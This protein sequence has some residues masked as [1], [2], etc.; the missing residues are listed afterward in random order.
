MARRPTADHADGL[1]LIHTLSDGKQ[2]RHGPKRL[3]TK[4]HIQPSGNHTLPKVSQLIAERNH[5]VVKKLHLIN[6]DKISCKVQAITE[7][8]AISYRDS[9]LFETVVG[10]NRGL[11]VPAVNGVFENLDLLTCDLRTTEA[12]NQFLGFPA[13]HTA[14]YNLNPAAT[15]FAIHRELLS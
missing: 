7:L 1:Q 10:G 15:G 2:T 3:S 8:S 12:A 5:A 11:T 4:V 14:A 6:G 13:K 9:R